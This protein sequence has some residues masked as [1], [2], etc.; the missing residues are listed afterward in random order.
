MNI[1]YA[2]RGYATIATLPF[3]APVAAHKEN[4]AAHGGVTL[5]QLR[6]DI[7]GLWCRKVNSNGNHREYG[8]RFVPTAAQLAHW[9]VEVH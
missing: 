4:R 2:T 8:K 9:G 3:T 7:D 1:H 5:I 6:R